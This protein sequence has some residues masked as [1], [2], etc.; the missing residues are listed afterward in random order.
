MVTDRGN[1]ALSM[2]VVKLLKTQDAGYLRTMVQR[3]RKE[4]E[5]LEEEMR[6]GE[7]EEE[8]LQVLKGDGE[9]EKRGKHTVFVDLVQQQKSFEPGEWF[10]TDRDGLE[11]SYNRPRRRSEGVPSTREEDDAVQHPENANKSRSQ[12]AKDA[13]GQA[14]KEAHALRRRRQKAQEVR[15][16]RLEALRARERDL[17]LAEQEL[18]NQRAKMTNT[19]GGVNKEGVK[20]KVRERK[21]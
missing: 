3:T 21:R 17:Q 2:D 14:V 16:I 8:D 6:L 4:R 12:R 7:G 15:R 10:G 11:K 9:G 1:T 13:E 18:E 20:F 19:L 5:R